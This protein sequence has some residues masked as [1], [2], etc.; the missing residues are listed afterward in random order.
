VQS[1]SDCEVY[2]YVP[3]GAGIADP[4]AAQLAGGMPLDLGFVNLAPALAD[5]FGAVGPGAVLGA[6]DLG[7][8]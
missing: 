2:S 7:T 3:A 8:A 4:I 5:D 1:L 6:L